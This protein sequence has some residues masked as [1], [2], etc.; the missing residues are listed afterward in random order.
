MTE[1][2]ERASDQDAA[3]P[4][5][6]QLQILHNAVMLAISLERD[7]QKANGEL[8]AQSNVIS[9]TPDVLSV[10]HG[11]DGACATLNQRRFTD[12]VNEVLLSCTK[13]AAQKMLAAAGQRG[14]YEV[15]LQPHSRLVQV[16]YQVGI[17]SPTQ[18]LVDA[19]GALKA[20]AQ[21]LNTTT[22]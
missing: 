2:V 17:F 21:C 19:D 12:T 1:K 11:I 15:S 13:I 22:R 14:G 3:K 5:L 20:V 8:Q 16:R 7:L 6:A 9:G 4:V 18:G 10:T